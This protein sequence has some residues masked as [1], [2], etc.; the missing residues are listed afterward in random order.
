MSGVARRPSVVQTRIGR[1]QSSSR[2]GAVPAMKKSLIISLAQLGVAFSPLARQTVTFLRP[3]GTAKSR[4]GFPASLALKTSLKIKAAPCTP[5]TTV[6]FEL[7][8]EG[9]PPA[10]V[11]PIHEPMT[12]FGL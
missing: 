5:P 12:T 8:F 10:Q 7:T 2:L 11:Q 6:R 9:H 1:Y 3:S 4:T